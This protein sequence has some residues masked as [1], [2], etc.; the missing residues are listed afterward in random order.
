MADNKPWGATAGDWSLFAKV[1][2]LRADLLPVVSNPNAPI[3]SGSTM[4][5]KGKTPSQFN[6]DGEVVGISAWTSRTSTDTD[7]K[8]WAAHSDL[9]ICVQTRTV[10]AIDIDIPDPVVAARVRDVV[11]L[12]L[13]RVLP[14]RGRSN[15]GK[16]LL[17]FKMPGTFTKRIIRCEGG[18]IEFLANGQQF[19]AVGTHPSGERYSWTWADGELAIPTLT[20]D[21]FEEVWRQL[22]E[23]FAVE[24]TATGRGEG[25]K[26][27]SMRQAGDAADPVI[28]FLEATGWVKSWQKD[29][30]LNVRCP[31]ES[32]HTSESGE[33][34]SVWFPAGVG[35]FDKGNYRCLHAHC[36]HRSKEDF[37]AA[38]GYEEDLAESF[39]IITVT[40]DGEADSAPALPKPI[41]QRKRNGAILGN[42][43]NTEL[44]LARPDVVLRYLAWDEFRAELVTADWVVEAHDTLRLQ[45]RA[46]T[47]NDYTLMKLRLERTQGF[48]T[49]SKDNM[50]DAVRAVALRNRFD[51]AIH[52]LTHHVPAWDGVDRIDAYYSRCLGAADTEYAQ[53]VAAYTWTALAGRVLEPG[54]KADMVPVLISG[55]GTGKSTS[56]AAMVPDPEAHF[57][58]IDLMRRDDDLSRLMRGKL[59]G[60]IAELRGLNTRDEESIKAWVTRR[61]E[62]WTPKYQEF[63]TRFARRLLFIGTSNQ[64]DFLANDGSAARRWLPLPVGRTDLATIERERLQLWAEARE[65]FQANGVEWQEAD[66]LGKAAREDHRFHDE[67]QSTIEHWLAQGDDMGEADSPP[68]GASPVVVA[69]VLVS[70]IGL[71]L[72]RC[73][74]AEQKRAARVL[75]ALGYSRK[76]ARVAGRVTWTY[77]PE[78]SCRFLRTANNC[79]MDLA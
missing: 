7:I 5:E 39:D 52:W 19:V 76:K 3:W 26:P 38:V 15:S 31:W 37:F 58:E 27:L 11:E 75:M 25:A 61:F 56:V 30:R 45:W 65:R 64:W 43:S 1:F 77:C 8:R 44:A 35:G 54:C 79:A 55:E 57:A 9:G 53:A 28:D 36:E 33:T 46:F 63:G 20:Q 70:A 40:V 74:Q 22:A 71:P 6:R 69:D 24:P 66:R 59:V 14:A 78:P 67:W 13:D 17:A 2:G 47:D 29:G 10:R 42:I 62:E 72:T 16:C 18:I 48:E 4:S 51:S 60:E 21:Q 23:L 50:R 68:R 49:I 34:A 12:T 32:E 73:G 41:Y